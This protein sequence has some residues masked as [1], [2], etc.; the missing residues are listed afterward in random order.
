MSTLDT[1]VVETGPEPVG[2]VIWLHGLGADGH[3]FEALVPELRLPSTLPLRFVFPHAP[4]RPVTI[5]GGM[6]MRAWYDIKSFDAEGRAD[7]Q[8]IESSSAAL[9]ALVA[10]EQARGFSSSRIV[11]AGFSQGGAVVLHNAL[12]CRQALGG[13]MALSTYLA[14]PG[15]F[16]AEVADNPDSQDRSLPVFVAH[17][18]QDPVVPVQAG[19]EAVALLKAAGFEPSW[20]EYT[21]PHSVCPA[22]VADIRAWLLS[23]YG[24]ELPTA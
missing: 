18:T 13:L 15:G 16:A 23:V 1:V 10:D 3:D 5:N 6:A 20:H 24:S 21:M 17:G 22:E 4:V 11:L 7:R 14:L 2:V 8:G 12:R 9:D 19:R